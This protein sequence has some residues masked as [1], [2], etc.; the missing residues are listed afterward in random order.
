MPRLTDL[1]TSIPAPRDDDMCPVCEEKLATVVLDLRLDA[2]TAE[3][4]HSLHTRVCHDC[5]STLFE[6]LS[7]VLGVP[8]AEAD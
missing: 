6:S 8:D 4:S 7:H 5:A 2:T 3:S 1:L